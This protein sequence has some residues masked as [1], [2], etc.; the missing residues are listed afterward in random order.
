[1][2]LEQIGKRIEDLEGKAA[3]VVE[4]LE[5]SEDPA[6]KQELTD[7]ISSL[8]TD[9]KALTAERDQAIHQKALEDMRG[10]VL[11]MK[12]AIEALREPTPFSF[13][14]SDGG[15]T[16]E[17]PYK[18]TSFYADAKAVMKDHDNAA[19]E[20]WEQAMGE[21][22][23]MTQGTGSAGGFLVPN[24]ISTELIQLREQLATLRPLFSQVQVSSDTL[25]IASVTGGLVAGWVAE[26]AEKPVG[27]L[28]FGE[29]SVNVFTAAGLAVVSNQLL[30][31]ANR[32]VDTLINTDLAKRLK[33]LEELAFI[34][35]SGT[36]QT[37]SSTRSPPSTPTSTRLPM[38]S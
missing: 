1:M 6:E 29:Q 7:K 20:R 24:Q 9:V 22:K 23:A 5:K 34:G 8:D 10:Q 25:Q 26:L 14:G 13:G 11:D 21:G 30:R 19:R 32:S 12:G 31:N 35:G 27:D 37:R 38:G 36:G 2:D 16:G 33:N 3:E 28:T 18:D 15:D 17:N 4:Q